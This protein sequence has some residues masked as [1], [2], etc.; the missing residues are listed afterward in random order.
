MSKDSGFEVR[1]ESGYEDR[2]SVEYDN[3]KYRKRGYDT[4]SQGKGASSSTN[5]KSYTKNGNQL[6][7]M[8][9]RSV[10]GQVSWINEWVGRLVGLYGIW[11]WEKNK[12]I[13]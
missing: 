9:F 12:F 11:L 7:D 2:R 5:D 13:C 8:D 1:R 10:G 3:S 4:S 6:R